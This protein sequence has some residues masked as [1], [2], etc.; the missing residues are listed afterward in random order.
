MKPYCFKCGAEL[1]P[2]AIYCPDCGR[3]QRSMVVRAVGSGPRSEPP[4]PAVPPEDGQ[5]FDD[6][7]QHPD[8]SQQHPEQAEPQPGQREPREDP[9]WYPAGGGHQVA[10]PE[11]ADERVYAQRPFPEQPYA[12]QP[13]PAQEYP[14]QPYQAHD[15]AY[16]GEHDAY[17]EEGHAY[18]VS[19][20]MQTPED[21]TYASREP[22]GTEHGY[23]GQSYPDQGYP[24]QGYPEQGY[25]EQS[26][27]EQGYS[28]QSHPDQGY[29]DQS[30][31]DQGYAGS[32]Y[33][34]EGYSQP[35]PGQGSEYPGQ[36]YADRDQASTSRSYSNEQDATYSTLA[37]PYALEDWPP[38]P[39]RRQLSWVRLVAI[40]A[41]GLLGLFLV[42]FAIGKLFGGS[43]S[44]ETSSAPPQQQSAQ[45]ATASPSTQSSATPAP[46]ATPDQGTG[47][48]NFQKVS[49]DIP[50]QCST[51]QGCPIRVTVK[52]TGGPGAGT[53][54]V[55]LTDT[56]G[57]TVATYSGR[58]P[59]TVPGDTVQVNGYATGDRLPDYLRSGGTVFI[60]TVTIKNT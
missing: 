34:E 52:N 14:E 57:N 26:Y 37:D 12:G 55:T 38:V 8:Q 35:Y 25:P 49:A 45:V 10:E 31:P 43:S 5:S 19:E 46:T 28:D 4:G 41:A 15:D 42:G 44:P 39:A 13:Y 29:S 50:S 1:D 59:V 2:E 17:A 6:Q 7:P 47:T 20:H 22:A 48:A 32:G 11:P 40:A 60:T 21:E 23:P 56:G 53:V 54:S 9:G 3:L 36:Q 24:E 58:I 51:R 18:D 16:A 27:P 33:P 30:H